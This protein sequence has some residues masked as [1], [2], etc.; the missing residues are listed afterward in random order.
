MIHSAFI[1][2]NVDHSLH[3][4]QGDLAVNSSSGSVAAEGSSCLV[5]YF[6]NDIDTWINRQ[7]ALVETLG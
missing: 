7:S 6:V 4:T 1:D 3:A 5:N 2:E